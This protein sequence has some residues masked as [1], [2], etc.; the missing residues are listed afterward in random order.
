M[1]ASRTSRKLITTVL[2]AGAGVVA[3]QMADTD[4]T[5][6]AGTTVHATFAP[7]GTGSVRRPP[8]PVGLHPTLIPQL[9]AGMSRAE[10]EELVGLPEAANV[11]PVGESNGRPTY[12]TTYEFEFGL[13]S[14]SGRP[15][16]GAEPLALIGFEF[17]ASLPGHPL[18]NV[19]YP[20]PLF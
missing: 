5:P 13:G 4:S 17:D 2:A 19:L 3:W 9:Q 10:V 6:P 20:D 18:V 12:Q 7:A 8:A 14:G 1:R 15:V 11:R 16:P